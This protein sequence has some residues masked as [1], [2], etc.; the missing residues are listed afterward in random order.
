MTSGGDFSEA[1]R[2]RIAVL[3]STRDGQSERIAQRIAAC[4]CDSGAMTTL[5]QNGPRAMSAQSASEISRG[6]GHLADDA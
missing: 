6:P 1:G 2:K 3:Y 5:H 4:L